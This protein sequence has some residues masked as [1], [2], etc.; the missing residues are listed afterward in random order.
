MKKS[1]RLIVLTIFCLNFFS[2]VGEAQSKKA[3]AET[4]RF[5]DS[6]TGKSISEVLVIPRYFSFQGVSTM[7]GEGPQSGSNT[8]YL[9]KPFVYR[10]GQPFD[11]K[12][13]K[14]AGVNAGIFF[15]GKGR[16][17]QGFYFVAPKYRPV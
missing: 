4:L 10:A 16:S 15:V 11:V 8:Y 14:S 5:T 1:A 6:L 9:D 13:P 17:L 2:V 3:P 7:L 12:R